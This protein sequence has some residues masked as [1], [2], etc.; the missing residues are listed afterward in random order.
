[1]DLINEAV[2]KFFVYA[3]YDTS[4]QICGLSNHFTLRHSTPRL[5]TY[6]HPGYRRV[7][8]AQKSFELRQLCAGVLKSKL[9]IAEYENRYSRESPKPDYLMQE[10]GAIRSIT[11]DGGR[12]SEKLTSDHVRRRG[13]GIRPLLRHCVAP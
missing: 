2:F 4:Q 9:R 13:C 12:R 7:I 5:R 3:A 8:E 11:L 10:T 6:K 1:M